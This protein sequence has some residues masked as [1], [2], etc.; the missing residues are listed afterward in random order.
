MKKLKI[1]L[2][3]MPFF[4]VETPSFS[5][6]VLKHTLQSNY[7]DNVEVDICYI[8]HDFAKF[9][10]LGISQTISFSQEVFATGIGE[11]IFKDIAFPDDIVDPSSYFMRYFPGDK[12]E[13]FR[14]FIIDRKSKLNGFI[15]NM[16]DKYNLNDADIVGFTSMF[17]QNL[18]S[19]AMANE[20]KKQ[21][22]NCIITM[23]GAN[24][25]YPMGLEIVRNIESI[26]YTFSGPSVRSIVSF[27]DN[28][29]NKEYAKCDLINGVFSKSN[30]QSIEFSNDKGKR[31]IG[32]Y[33]DINEQT[34][35]DYDDYFESI[36]RIFPDENIEPILFFQT[37]KGCWWGQ[38][39]Q[40]AFCGLN[41]LDISF[42]AMN[43][44]NAK[45]T[46]ENLVNKY[47]DRCQRFMCVDN[48]IHN[49]YPEE[50][51]SKLEL[52]RDVA[53]FYE[54]RPTLTLD[55]LRLLSAAG[56]KQVGP[57]I[58]SLSTESLKLMKKGLSVFQNIK[59]L[60]NCLTAGVFPMWNLLIGLPFEPPNTYKNYI[61]MFP[62]LHHLVPPRFLSQIV[63]MP[64]SV[65]FNNSEKY[66]LDLVPYDFYNMVYPFDSNT[67]SRLAYFFT[68]K[69]LSDSYCD[70]LEIL[71][72]L[73]KAM[74]DWQ[75]KWKCGNDKVPMLYF[76]NNNTIFDFRDGECKEII[77]SDYEKDAL[78]LLRDEKHKREIIDLLDYD[79]MDADEILYLLQQKRLILVDNDFYMSLVMDS[80]PEKLTYDLNTYFASTI[81]ESSWEKEFQELDIQ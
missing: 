44:E 56:V 57:G 33:H 55:Q 2:V 52:K 63:F 25:Q 75:E 76:K 67:I 9:I 21:N 47:S 16:I 43:Y 49:K 46:I 11:W 66:Q 28:I 35:I 58:E 24:C 50:V 72:R 62:D 77:L 10:G 1:K 71:P 8:N 64:N 40:C 48:I 69:N 53:M 59:F 81:D 30:I 32:C 27:I 37:S 45:Y 41:G 51:F 12:F 36:D 13:N 18:S 3:V 73:K 80:K 17:S 65:Y 42:E 19:F 79:F 39:S 23:G 61:N 22:P 5:V 31:I 4:Q 20:I 54:V 60:K 74:T 29:L 14:N 26:D 70:M 68:N 6:T 7:S 15:S 34:E 38:K 78:L